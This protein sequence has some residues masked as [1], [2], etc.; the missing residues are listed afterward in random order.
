MK[1]KTTLDLTEGPI[2]SKLCLFAL[3]LLINSFVNHLYSTADTMVMGR[4]GGTEA[5]AAVGASAMPLTLLVSMF[6]GLSLG[7]TVNCGNLKG[8]HK[9]KELSDCMHTGALM[10]F[11]IGVIICAVGITAT[12]PILRLMNTP[13]EI[14]DSAALYMTL[15]FAPCPL[16]IFAVFGDS[17]FYAHGESQIPTIIGISCGLVN[18]ALN[19]VFVA[20]LGM[21]VEGVALATAISQ[22]LNAITVA[23]ILFSRKGMFKMSFTKLRL[24]WQYVRSI[25]TVGIPNSLS[26]MVFSISN[27]FMQSAVNRFGATAIAG[28]IAA[29]ELIGYPSLILTAIRSACVSA[30]A[31]CCGAQKYQRVAQIAKISAPACTALIVALAIP[32]T[33]F[34]EELLLL[35]CEDLSVAQMGQPKLL[36]ACWGYI[37]FG[38]GKVYGGCLAGMRKANEGLACEIVGIIIPR[39]LWIWFVVPHFESISWLY[40]VYPLTWL[41]AAVLSMICF[42][43]YLRKAMQSDPVPAGAG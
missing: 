32:L 36:I 24:H 31:Q 20:G 19:M 9:D 14:L 40:V 8:G 15:R 43:H 4:F 29:S 30:T 2:L 33:L 39:L 6:S 18:V 25:L 41:A 26:N 1:R 16:W 10:G 13:A 17:I 3:P 5:M 22:V 34:S 37:L 42:R 12:R 7:V 11:L 23:T 38:L 21:G 27:V 28:N 35:F